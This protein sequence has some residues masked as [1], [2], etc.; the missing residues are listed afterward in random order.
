MNSYFR[1]VRA[2][3]EVVMKTVKVTIILMV[4][5]AIAA[6]SAFAAPVRI[7]ALEQGI[8]HPVRV[9]VDARGN[10]YV[11]EAQRNLVAV[12]DGTGRYRASLAVPRPLG[13]AV[14]ANGALYVG[15]GNLRKGN[16]VFVFNPD[17]SGAGCLGSGGC[18][19]FVK[20]NDITIDRTGKI[21]VVESNADVSAVRVFDA[22]GVESSPILGSGASRLRKPMGAAVNDATGEIF[23]T[24]FPKV[25]TSSGW[26]D[27]ARIQVFNQQGTVLRSF[28]SF[29]ANVGQILAPT[30]ISLDGAGRLYVSDA[31]QNVVNIMNASDGAITGTLSD[32]NRPGFNPNGVVVTRNGLAYVVMQ[33]GES[34]LGRVDIYALDGF[35]TM[36]ASP[37]S[38][39]FEGRQY[40]GN[41]EAQGVIIE[42][43][44][45]GTL[46]WTA[47]VDQ[48]WIVLNQAG[49]AVGPANKAALAV[50]V[51]TAN[52]PV[53]SYAGTVTIAS[54][55]GQTSTVAVS[56]SVSPPPVLTLSDGWLAFEGKKGKAVPSKPVTVAIEN[57]ASLAWSARSDS[58]WL[59]LTPSS[60]TATTTAAV[61]VN[62][63]GMQAGEYAGHITFHAAGAIGDGSGITVN[64]TV[65]PS[66]RITV[67]T[68]LD[69]AVFSIAGPAAY[70]GGGKNWSV[71]DVPNGSY[72]VSFDKVSG[73][74]KEPPQTQTISEANEAIVFDAPYDPNR[75]T[76]TANIAEAQFT[77][78][79]PETYT[80]S[81]ANWSKEVVPEGDYTIAY[82]RTAGYK[83]PKQEKKTLGEAGEAAFNAAYPSWMELAAKK[84]IV[85]GKGPGPQNSAHLKTYKKDGTVASLDLTAFDTLYGASVAAADIDG[86]GIAEVIAG[87]GAGPNNSALV[88]I[89][90]A[91]GTKLLEFTPFGSFCGVNAAAADLDG[92][93]AAE[94][95]VAP[96]A[97]PQC[98]DV[99]PGTVKVYAYNKAGGDMVPTGIEI[100]AHQGF[101]GATVAAADT[102]GDWL[103]ELVTAPGPGPDNPAT[104]RIWSVDASQGIGKWTAAQSG[105]IVVPG[106]KRGATVAAG[107]AN[108][109]E[110]DEIIVGV[111]SGASGS[112]SALV[113][114]FKADGAE[115]KTFAASGYKYGANVA[116]G[117]LDGDGIVE[118]VTGAGPDPGAGKKP[119]GNKTAEPTVKIFGVTGT[120]KISLSPYTDTGYGA[121]VA[122]GELGL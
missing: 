59:S 91:D 76:V 60:G 97:S 37:S 63:A 32:A 72:T 86:D 103:P 27:G 51:N 33:K 115:V 6:G 40:L 113:K 116:A 48:P 18:A 30:D 66:T 109:D 13:L 112:A 25:Y 88:R 43:S 46:N 10:V 16:S 79:G 42:N 65:K 17:L 87:G 4:A 61:T 102:E 78:T 73:Y 31:F 50:G 111:D 71:E 49:G 52:L 62:T 2:A 8:E 100:T 64:L 54:D 92:N 58:T 1:R 67:K 74:R 75:I 93:G 106:F 101:Y 84:T 119:A 108:G 122:V 114:I 120:E 36:A 99:N 44:G 80:G 70:T 24:D 94:V 45:S 23:I 105:E 22:S 39:A 121:K 3:S 118:I 9:A 69:A 34:S 28:G 21:L 7:G 14:A 26:V 55:F 96:G 89:F 104:V 5:I 38:L 68:N 41:P 98:G 56:L 47:S 12:Y 82:A 19:Q 117:D 15:S 85:T 83:T 57:A 110:K 11:S 53:G 107:D 81:G 29:G 90:K 77:I 35:V 95:I 20:P